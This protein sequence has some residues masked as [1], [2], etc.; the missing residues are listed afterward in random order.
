MYSH[1]APGT[2]AP[3][4]DCNTVFE[5]SICTWAWT[6]GLDC[7]TGLW[8]WTVGLD[9]WTGLLDWTVGLDCRT[10]LSDWTVGLD[11]GPWLLDWTVGL[12]SQKVVLIQF[13][14]AHTL[15]HYSILTS[16]ELNSGQMAIT[17]YQCR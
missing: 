16:L 10:G 1:R 3:S 9:C 11:C 15:L 6:V 17:H 5:W 12:D 2:S 4:G 7:W 14:A 8:D 13:E